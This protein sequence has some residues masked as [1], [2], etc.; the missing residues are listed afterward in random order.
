[1]YVVDEGSRLIITDTDTA[2]H[3]TPELWVRNCNPSN[4]GMVYMTFRRKVARNSVIQSLINYMYLLESQKVLRENGAGNWAFKFSDHII[5]RDRCRRI[6]NAT[7]GMDVENWSYCFIELR[8]NGLEVPEPFIWKR[9]SHFGDGYS[10]LSMSDRADWY[11][12]SS[13]ELISLWNA[14]AIVRQE[15]YDHGEL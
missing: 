8:Q 7:L 4:G 6:V 15:L 14:L 10:V 2:N 11:S 9:N 12:A 1:M 13:E 5:R 3:V